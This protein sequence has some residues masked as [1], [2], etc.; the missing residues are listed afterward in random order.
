MAGYH[1]RSIHTDQSRRRAL[2]TGQEPTTIVR[3]CSDSQ[4]GVVEFSDGVTE[5]G[6]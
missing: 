4:T 6:A 2:V 3:G 1:D 5:A